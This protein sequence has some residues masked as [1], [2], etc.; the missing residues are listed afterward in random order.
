MLYNP[1]L[2][3]LAEFSA[4]D[5]TSFSNSGSC[6]KLFDTLVQKYELVKVG[7]V[8]HDF[9]GA[10]FTGLVCLTESHL[11]IHTW[12][13]FNVA[14]FDIYLSNFQKDNS[15]KVRAIYREVL[16]FF[17]GSEIQVNELVR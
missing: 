8:Y 10:G 1:G 16:H 15:S 11:S 2:H 6:K 3:V 13:E 5:A 9:E 17:Q 12:P 14:T 7:E 4:A